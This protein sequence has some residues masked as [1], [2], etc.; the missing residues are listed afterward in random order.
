VQ[1]Q[2]RQRLLELRYIMI[3]MLTVAVA[4]VLLWELLDPQVK[5]D[6]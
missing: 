2:L 3:E 5:N 6:D 4:L 1:H